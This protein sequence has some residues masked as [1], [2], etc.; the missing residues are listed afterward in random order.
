MKVSDILKRKKVWIFLIICITIYRSTSALGMAAYSKYV[1][2]SIS[3]RSVSILNISIIG[4]LVVF[5]G[6]SSLFLQNLI[7]DLFINKVTYEIRILFMKSL[8]KHQVRKLNEIGEGK[9]ITNYTQDYK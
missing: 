3:E 8:M 4:L 5:W 1:F 7:I 2:D 9:L 6:A